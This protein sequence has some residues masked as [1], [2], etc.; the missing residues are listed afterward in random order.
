[1]SEVSPSHLYRH[2]HTPHGAPRAHPSWTS[3][4]LCHRFGVSTEEP[5][6]KEDVLVNSWT[7]STSC[8]ACSVGM[9]FRNKTVCLCWIFL[10]IFWHVIDNVIIR[11]SEKLIVTQKDNLSQV[12]WRNRIRCLIPRP[13]RW[14]QLQQFMEQPNWSMNVLNNCQS[15]QSIT[16]CCVQ[17]EIL[18]KGWNYWSLRPQDHR[19]CTASSMV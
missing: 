17:L 18:V 14:Q 2:R 15:T 4:G 7:S 5:V 1:M 6:K 8:K 3:A 10:T 12:F 16:L 9:L 19:L 11:S 13:Y